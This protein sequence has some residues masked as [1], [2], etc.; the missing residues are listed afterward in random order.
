[1]KASWDTFDSYQVDMRL[2]TYAPSSLFYFCPWPDLE[3]ESESDDKGR[4]REQQVEN[5]KESDMERERGAIKIERGRGVGESQERGGVAHGKG[6]PYHDDIRDLTDTARFLRS[7][8]YC[9]VEGIRID[10][11]EKSRF[12]RN[13]FLLAWYEREYQ[14]EIAKGHLPVP[15]REEFYL[16]VHER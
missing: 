9:E 13:E 11:P 1:M 10:K 6:P 14:T 15:S 3:N 12:D 8:E 2:G 7:T 16:K 4:E 5:E